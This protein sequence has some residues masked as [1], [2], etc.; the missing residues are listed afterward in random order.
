M[1]ETPIVGGGLTDRDRAA[2][3]FANDAFYAAFSAKDIDQMTALWAEADSVGCIHPGWPPLHG[4]ETVLESWRRILG[5]PETP[6]ASAR[7]PRIV[8][9]G[10]DGAAVICYEDLGGQMLIATNSFVREGDK[11]TGGVWRICHHHAAAV[12]PPEDLPEQGPGGMQ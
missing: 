3:L 4:R 1:A 7:A 12:P 9:Q 6:V 10:P 11:A 8:P 5:N 2:I